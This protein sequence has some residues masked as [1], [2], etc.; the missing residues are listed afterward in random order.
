MIFFGALSLFFAATAC[1]FFWQ[2]RQNNL[3]ARTLLDQE[4]L[5]SQEN[6]RLRSEVDRLQ[7]E[8]A[9][10]GDLLKT[11]EEAIQ[12]KQQKL[13]QAQTEKEGLAAE[14]Q[15]RENEQKAQKAA[16]EER[17]RKLREA[18]RVPDV[19][20][21]KQ[22]DRTTFTISTQALFKGFEPNLKEDGRNLLKKLLGNLKNELVDN[23]LR[24]EAHSDNDPI[25]GPAKERFPTN[26]DLS[27]SR[28]AAVVRF[29]VEQNA[30]PANRIVAVGHGDSRPLGDNS[31]K[32]GRAQNRR[33]ELI[34]E[35][36]PRSL[37]VSTPAPQ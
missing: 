20:M 2:N 16:K 10:V 32:E 19:V 27:S 12:Q 11:R 35:A 8:I 36:L 9:Q 37:Q 33:I 29:L 7:A 15:A 24:V 5:L 31:T 14:K 18:G 34:L 22:D 28:A 6:R 13:E 17:E 23:E 4:E 21:T 25:T 26:W 1:Y 30:V 3:S